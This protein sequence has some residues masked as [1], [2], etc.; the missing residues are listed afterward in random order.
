[1]TNC[2]VYS[3]FLHATSKIRRQ[4]YSALK[5]PLTVSKWFYWLIFYQWKFNG[6]VY[7]GMLAYSP[8]EK[9]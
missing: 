5:I 1:M 6:V 8:P 7:V 4:M 3:Q 2:T 9:H